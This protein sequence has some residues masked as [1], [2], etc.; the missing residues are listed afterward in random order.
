MSL[1]TYDF[2]AFIIPAVPRRE[3]WLVGPL[4]PEIP[5]W[6][7]WSPWHSCR[8][9]RSQSFGGGEP[10]RSSTRRRGLSRFARSRGVSSRPLVAK[11]YRRKAHAVELTGGGGPDG[12]IDLVAKKG[13]TLPGPVQALRRPETISLGRQD[14]WLDK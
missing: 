10:G 12:G 1:A 2:V 9:R 7:P 11:A 6:H 14:V 4:T 13:R 3:D 5:A 8:P